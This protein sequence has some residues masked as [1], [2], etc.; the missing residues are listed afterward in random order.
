METEA[1][2]TVLKFSFALRREGEALASSSSRSPST[3]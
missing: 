3:F 2:V 1:W